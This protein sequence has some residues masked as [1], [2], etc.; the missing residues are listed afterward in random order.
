MPESPPPCRAAPVELHV[1]A[2]WPASRPGPI[3]IGGTRPPLPPGSHRAFFTRLVSVRTSLSRFAFA[4]AALAATAP[5]AAAQS[6]AFYAEMHW[7]EIGPT[8]AG[9]ARALAGVP[10]QPNVFYIGFD[11][12]GVWRS[13][14]YGSTWVPLFDSEPTGSIGA[15]AVAPSNPNVIY[16]GIGR[17]HHPPRPLHGRRRVQVDRRRQD[18]DAP[19]T[20]RH[21]DDRDDRRGPEESGPAV[22]RGARPSV[23]PERGARHLP[24]D[25]RR[26]DVPEGAVQGRVHERQRRAHR[27]ERTR[28]SSTP[29]SGS[30]SRA[31][32]RAREFGGAGNGIFKSTDGGT[33]W[34]Q[35]TD[36]LPRG[37][38]GQPRASRPSNP[39]MLYAMV[40]RRR[41]PAGR[42]GRRRQ[43][44]HRH[45]RLLQVHRRRRAL[46]PGPRRPGRGIGC[47]ARRSPTRARWRASAAATC[48]RSP[49]TRR[50]RT[51]STARRPCSGAPRTAA[52]PGRPCAAPRAATTTRRSGSTRTNRTSCSSCPTRAAWCR[53]TAARAGATGTRSPRRRC[54]T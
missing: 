33:T 38:R 9:R 37:D 11:N 26:P 15:I 12:G 41:A 8:R 39:N 23:R 24:L 50:T 43:R 30:S 3:L 1:A 4:L 29:R 35:L 5:A 40:G 42:G 32:A 47:P 17:R 54:I 21:A 19:R 51:S 44:H 36:G 53:P 14:D 49:S 22:R 6:P 25:R 48:P 20:A 52:S 10:S 27:S 18:L 7:R 28:A 31:S 16:V 13:T 2:D 46:A 34:Q 45:R